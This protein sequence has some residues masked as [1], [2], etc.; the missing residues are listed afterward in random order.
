MYVYS[1][2][3]FRSRH[4]LI[5]KTAH[6]TNRSNVLLFHGNVKKRHSGQSVLQS[7]RQV[8]M[9]A[10]HWDVRLWAFGLW[11]STADVP[12]VDDTCSRIESWICSNRDSWKTTSIISC[13]VRS[14]GPHFE[15]W[16]SDGTNESCSV[17]MRSMGPHF[18]TWRNQCVRV[19]NFV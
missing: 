5:Q 19:C 12:I 3:S 4:S 15:L 9:L 16:R 17:H 8:H 13:S 1:S 7:L 11:S 10:A 6:H 2:R 14:M 18:D